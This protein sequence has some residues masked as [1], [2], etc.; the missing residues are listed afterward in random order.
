M[1]HKATKRFWN[2]INIVKGGGSRSNLVIKSIIHF[3]LDLTLLKTEN[4]MGRL[5][6]NKERIIFSSYFASDLLEV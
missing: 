1:N 5:Q 6:R 2:S 4:S 3:R